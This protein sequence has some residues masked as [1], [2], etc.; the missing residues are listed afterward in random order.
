MAYSTNWSS[1]N[2]TFKKQQQ[3]AKLNI[4]L[5]KIREIEEIQIRIIKHLRNKSARKIKKLIGN[6]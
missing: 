4:Q 1:R 5:L 3:K 2:M 6:S